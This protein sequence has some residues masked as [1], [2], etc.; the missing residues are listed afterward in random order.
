M[1][2]LVKPPEIVNWN[3]KKSI[4]LA[5]TIDNGQSIDWQASVE[6][7]LSD[8]DILILNPRRDE[9]NATWEQSIENKQFKEQVEWELKGLEKVS[10]I[11]IY[12]A[13]NSKSPISLLELGLHASSGKLTI[14]CPQGFWR[15]GNIEVVASRFTIPLYESLEEGLAVIREKLA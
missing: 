6:E 1:A 13:P 2:N 9:W 15:R 10:Q 14:V 8:L 5:G 11:L 7:A 4:F 3:G 12:F